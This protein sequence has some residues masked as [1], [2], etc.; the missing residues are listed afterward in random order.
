LTR[1]IA[2]TVLQ[3]VLHIYNGVNHYDAVIYRHSPIISNH[4]YF[5]FP[6]KEVDSSYDQADKVMEKPKTDALGPSLETHQSQT[7]NGSPDPDVH[8]TN[9]LTV[10]SANV[11][12]WVMGTP[13]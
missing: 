8:S 12:S 13:F 2:T 4:R 10:L 3:F 5:S 1:P 9:D 6:D 7:S 11:S